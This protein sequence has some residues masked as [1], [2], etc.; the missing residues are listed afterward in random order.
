MPKIAPVPAPDAPDSAP[1]QL[2]P[3]QVQQGLNPRPSKAAG[4]VDPYR[5][6]RF[7]PDLVGIQQMTIW[8]PGCERSLQL[9]DAWVT[10]HDLFVEGI[11]YWCSNRAGHKAGIYKRLRIPIRRGAEPDIEGD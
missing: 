5:G 3:V 2:R 11:C 10:S 8:C 6:G 7:A 1:L 4:V 9:I